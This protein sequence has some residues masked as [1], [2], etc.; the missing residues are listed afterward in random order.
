MRFS[1]LTVLTIAS[2]AF[3]FDF[4]ARPFDEAPHY[5]VCPPLVPQVCKAVIILLILIC[6]FSVNAAKDASSPSCCDR[7][8]EDFDFLQGRSFP[9]YSGLLRER[10]VDSKNSLVHVSRSSFPSRLDID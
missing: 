4:K 3:A 9:H 1:I 2:A 6:L 5:A 7:Y 10:A 8:S